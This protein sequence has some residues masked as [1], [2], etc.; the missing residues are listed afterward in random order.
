[1]PLFKRYKYDCVDGARFGR[2]KGGV[3]TTFIIYRI[4][5]TVIDTGPS[6]Q[7]RYVKR[8]L[9]EKPVEQV[10][11][12]HHHED[13]SG[14]AGRIS[15]YFNLKPLAPSLSQDK[16]RKGYKT[17][18]LQKLIWGSPRK[19]ETNPLPQSLTLSNELH[20]TAHHTPGHAKD[21][22]VF[23]VPERGWLFSGDLYISKSLKYLRSDEDL[24]LL[25]SSI[26][27]A[28]KLDFDR[29]F[30]PHRG[31]LENG[32]AE[33]QQKLTNMQELCE[34]VHELHT[35]G[36]EVEEIVIRLLGPE[37]HMA[38]VTRYNFSK[39]NLFTEALK[40]KAA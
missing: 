10:L 16:L 7:W 20:L 12:T 17:P 25:M 14:N 32:K 30:C 40:V 21:L 37:D 1:M 38:K 28:L 11:L 19:V 18:L 33:L 22:H 26:E 2:F 4:G 13:H 6:N 3:N 34:K 29:L 24:S 36:A 8:F 9:D 27:K 23:H 15:E 35:N 31:I 5:S 39:R